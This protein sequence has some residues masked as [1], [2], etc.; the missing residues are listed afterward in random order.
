MQGSD[1]LHIHTTHIQ[2]KMFKE[3]NVSMENKCPLLFPGFSSCEH[4]SLKKTQYF[5][6]FF[7]FV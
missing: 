5:S 3:M 7:V 1:K 4:G 6:N 2:L